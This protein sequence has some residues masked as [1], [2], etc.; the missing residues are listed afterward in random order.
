MRGRRTNRRIT[1]SN[2]NV[3]K[4]YVNGVETRDWTVIMVNI[5]SYLVVDNVLDS[6]EI[7]YE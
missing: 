3:S 7:T 5:Y 2:P 6:D 1:L 4:V